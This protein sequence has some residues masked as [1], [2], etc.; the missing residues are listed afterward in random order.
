MIK[1]N[2]YLTII[3]K[4]KEITNM[5]LQIQMARNSLML[6]MN[7]LLYLMNSYFL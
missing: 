3:S 1:L 2:I 4:S 5:V 6:I 7:A